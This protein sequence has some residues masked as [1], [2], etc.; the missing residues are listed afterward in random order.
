MRW[1]CVLKAWCQGSS[2]DHAIAFTR[3]V[4]CF[5]SEAIKQWPKVAV[6]SCLWGHAPFSLLRHLSAPSASAVLRGS[7]F[8]TSSW[9]RVNS[10]DPLTTILFPS[11]G[12]GS[13]HHMTL[14]WMDVTLGCCRMKRAQTADRG[15][16]AEM[17]REL[18][19]APWCA[20]AGEPAWRH[21]MRD[22]KSPQGLSHPELGLCLF[23]ALSILTNPASSRPLCF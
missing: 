5:I 3:S 7:W 2:M 23:A 4:G 14:S 13:R 8:Y 20:W 16:D 17:H 10:W 19:L 6:S 21:E 15:T 22:H 11:R 9:H 12:W 18:E 1:D